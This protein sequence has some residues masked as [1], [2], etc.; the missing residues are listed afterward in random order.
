M[1]GLYKNVVYF[2]C[3]LLLFLVGCVITLIVFVNKSGVM[4]QVANISSDA[5]NLFEDLGN[6]PTQIEEI[7][8]QID[9]ISAYITSM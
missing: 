3:L 6:I 4:N 1:K 8:T 9:Q 5:Q 2:N 7:K